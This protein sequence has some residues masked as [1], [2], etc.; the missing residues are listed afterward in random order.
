VNGRYG[1]V[2]GL[3]EIADLAGWTVEEIED[4]LDNKNQPENGG[5]R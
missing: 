3:F 5:T 2:E 1:W 4:L